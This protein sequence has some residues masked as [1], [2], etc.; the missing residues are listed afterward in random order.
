[1]CRSFHIVKEG[2]YQRDEL[3]DIM[4]TQPA[5]YEGCSGCRAFGDVE[6]DLKAQ[7][8]VFAWAPPP[9]T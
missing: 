8:R 2:K 9:A 7:V 5:K 3:Y 1:M 6:S 4:V